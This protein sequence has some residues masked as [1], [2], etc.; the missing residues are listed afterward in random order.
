MF[1][2][3]VVVMGNLKYTVSTSAVMICYSQSCGA[4]NERRNRNRNRNFPLV[5]RT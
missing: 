3:T 1:E 4:A 5:I 2:E